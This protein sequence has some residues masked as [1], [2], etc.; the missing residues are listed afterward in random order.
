MQCGDLRTSAQFTHKPKR[1]EMAVR[2][3]S[4]RCADDGRR[5][6]E[7]VLK[8]IYVEW[9]LDGQF[10]N[11]FFNKWEEYHALTFCPECHILKIKTI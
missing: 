2:N 7:K 9:T 8:M 10:N 1:S 4:P 6:R 11:A 5:E 3:D